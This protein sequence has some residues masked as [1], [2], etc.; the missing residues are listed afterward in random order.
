[1]S[2]G[3]NEDGNTE[4]VWEK[5]GKKGE[6]KRGKATEREIKEGKSED[7]GKRSRERGGGD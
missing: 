3:L 4:R 6:L 1:M 5:E 2:I 7:G